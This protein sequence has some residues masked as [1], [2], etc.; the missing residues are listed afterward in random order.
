MLLLRFFLRQ[1]IRNVL[2]GG[3]FLFCH[4]VLG[5]PYKEKTMKAIPKIE[6]YMSSM[7]H[8][9]N[10]DVSVKLA[11][12]MMRE[13]NCRHLPVQ[14]GG[15]L[16]GVLTDRDIK[17]ASSFQGP[18]ELSVEDVMTPDPY[19]VSPTAALDHVVLE[20]AEHKYGCA[21]IQQ[22]NG[23]VVGIFT[24]ND[25]LRV[26]GEVLEKHFKSIEN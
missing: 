7:P 11:M 13:Y 16:V 25:A 18:G 24:T 26:L 5:I 19:S 9:I 12:Q 20:M 8:T 21:V 1:G 10:P 22:E 14:N 17:L 2:N 23:R 15:K 6:K 4:V 3:G